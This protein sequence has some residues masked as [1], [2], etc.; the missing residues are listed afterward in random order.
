VYQ[1]VGLVDATGDPSWTM[2]K[3]LLDELPI[4]LNFES[5]LDYLKRNIDLEDREVLHYT[6]TLSKEELAWLLAALWERLRR[7]HGVYSF[8]RHNCSSALAQLIEL[9]LSREELERYELSSQLTTSPASVISRLQRLG[10]LSLT[11]HRLSARTKQIKRITRAL[12]DS[13][14]PLALPRPSASLTEQ[15]KGWVA[16]EPRLTAL[17]AGWGA[18]EPHSEA[19]IREAR[20]QSERLIEQLRSYLKLYDLE[21]W[22]SHPPVRE[23]FAPIAPRALLKMKHELFHVERDAEQ[24]ADLLSMWHRDTL[25]A[26]PLSPS[27]ELAKENAHADQQRAE[28]LTE[29]IEDLLIYA[30]ATHHKLFT[31]SDQLTTL[32]SSLISSPPPLERL[33]SRLSPRWGGD[34]SYELNLL[35][36][37][38]KLIS[39]LSVSLYD[40]RL[41][42]ARH[43]LFAGTRTLTIA[44]LSL[45][46][47]STAQT[48]SLTPLTFESSPRSTWSLL[49]TFS[50]SAHLGHQLPRGGAQLEGY[51]GVG[52]ALLLWADRR[53]Q[54]TYH[55]LGSGGAYLRSPWRRTLLGRLRLLTPLWGPLTLQATLTHSLAGR[56]ELCPSALQL[57]R[58]V[59]EPRASITEPL[60]SS[61]SLLRRLHER[62]LK[63]TLTTPL[64]T[65]AQH[66]LWLSLGALPFN[67]QRAVS[68]SLSF[69]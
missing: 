22:R 33:P 3:A 26:L 37:G 56:D 39:G 46:A 31:H 34:Q 52:S 59:Y 21:P 48:L 63:L 42:R 35:S 12:Q 65:Q 7:H 55:L 18:I 50:L 17:I 25:T 54:L 27:E 49:T 67:S 29:L 14:G 51:L 24:V 66:A 13:A 40:E 1:F 9:S 60:M 61:P 5:Y 16:L 30:Q 10:K 23:R 58:C 19:E 45:S 4:T 8:A 57:S 69:Y 15:L 6:M 53:G 62:S 68:V 44:Q 11:S 41:G 38:S 47:T 32:T 43:S 28:K 20:S 2:L 64:L 36:Q